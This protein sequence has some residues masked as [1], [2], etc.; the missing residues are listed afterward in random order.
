MGNTLLR[1]LGLTLA[2]GATV[3]VSWL[4]VRGASVFNGPGPFLDSSWFVIWTIEAGLAGMLG[5]AIGR[6]WGRDATSAR[7]IGLML[8][9]WIG[10]LV[11]ASA[12]APF[13]AGELSSVHG[14]SI[15]LVAT[16]GFIQVL[17]A[18]TG[19]LVGKAS[20]QPG[21]TAQTG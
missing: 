16:G 12:L 2:L 18:V 11:V 1:I 19:A 3:V 10:E 6:S 4:A 17:A 21:R 13:L 20:V 5:L 14:P 8:A 7:L 9:A 15:W